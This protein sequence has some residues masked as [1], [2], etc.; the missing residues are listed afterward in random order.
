MEESQTKASFISLQ[1]CSEEAHSE[2]A[3]WGEAKHL[4]KK[5]KG[6]VSGGM[7]IAINESG[8]PAPYS[9]HPTLEPLVT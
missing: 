6:G 8:S 3:Q 4:R 7:V 9:T 5:E 2:D 1:K